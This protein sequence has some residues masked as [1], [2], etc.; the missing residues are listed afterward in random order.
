MNVPIRMRVHGVSMCPRLQP[1]DIVYVQKA[2][3]YYLGDILVYRYD[4]DMFL[5][6]RF[7]SKHHKTLCCKGDNSFRIER[8]TNNDIIGKVVMIRRGTQLLHMEKVS[9][10]FLQ[11]SLRIG[12]I[13]EENAHNI[14]NVM[15]TAE[16]VEFSTRYLRNE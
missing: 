2:G 12:Q 10:N 1:N 8:I 6:H 13:F 11:E 4:T 7:L 16:Y 3:E 5:I 9:D 15:S 14:S